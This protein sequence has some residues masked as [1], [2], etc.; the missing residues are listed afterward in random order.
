M[1]TFLLWNVARQPIESAIAELARLYEI[2]VLIFAECTTPLGRMLRALNAGADAP[3]FLLPGRLC[4]RITIY[5]RFQDRFI[6]PVFETGRTTIRTLSLPARTEI[7]LAAT[8]LPSKLYWDEGSQAFEAAELAQAVRQVEEQIGHDR[9]ILVGDLNMNPFEPGLVAA[10]ALNA[11]MTRGIASRG[12]RTVQGREYPHFYNPNWGCFGDVTPGP[13][14]T[15]FRA[16]SVHK[17][18]FWSI[19]DQV[20]VRP[21]LLDRFAS[22]GVEILDG[23]GETSLLTES[24]VPSTSFSDHLPIMFRLSL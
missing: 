7:I 15:Y 20:L 24:G 8:H 4:E 21:S 18:T 3:Y 5:G 12:H 11:V 13:A 19:F 6:T 2:D 23:V 17:A 1:V 16:G 10:P 9:S 22:D 14:G